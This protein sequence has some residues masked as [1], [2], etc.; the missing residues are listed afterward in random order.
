MTARIFQISFYAQRPL[1]K[2]SLIHR[3]LILCVPSSFRTIHHNSQK[4]SHTDSMKS[5][6][7][8]P[9]RDPNTLS[10]YNKWLTAHTTANL[11]IQFDQQR[12]SGN[13]VLT[14]KSLSDSATKDI[15][16]DTSHLDISDIRVND[17]SAEWELLPR[18]EPYGSALKISLDSGLPADQ[19]VEV[20]MQISTTKSCTALQWLTPAQTSNKKH[21]YMFSQCQAIHARSIFPCQDTP[22]V[23]STFDF[24]ITSPLPVIASGLASTSN[25]TSPSPSGKSD[26]YKFH[27]PLPIPSYLFAIASGDI[28][29]ASIGP[30]SVVATSPDQLSACV[31]ELSADTESFLQAAEKIVYP[32]AW[33]QYNVL[34]LPP[35]FPYGGME[36]PIFTFATPTIISHD[37]QNVDVIAHELAHSWSGNLVSNASWQH[38][39]LNEGWTTY[40]ERRILAAIHGNDAWRDFSAI[41]GWQA[42][43]ESVDQYG[44]THEFTKLIVNLRGQDPDD[45]FSSVPYEKGFNLLYHLEKLVTQPKFDSFIP[46]Y[47]TKWRGKSLDSYEFR[48]TLLDFFADDPTA[49]EQ[50]AAV[51]WHTW[52]YAPG[53]PP[54]PDFDTQLVRPAYDLA[55]KWET[56]TKNNNKPQE[57]PFTP[58]PSDI[59]HLIG[60]QL[61]VFLDRLLTLSSSSDHPASA[62][63]A[64]LTAQMGTLYA[65]STSANVEL[66]SRWCQLALRARDPSCL[67]LVQD[68]LATVGRMKFVRPLY[69]IP[70]FPSSSFFSFLFFSFP[71]PPSLFL[72]AYRILGFF[73]GFFF[74][75]FCI[76]SLHAE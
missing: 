12:L 59:A 21:P 2:W 62:L 43:T 15:L 18:M 45:A 38:F 6:T 70:F 19:T 73:W 71:T 54:K 20:L 53:L 52:F 57:E 8:D 66:S 41:I 55:E 36:N 49:S 69:V 17:K 23:K 37:R 32:Y 5:P 1:P 28:V 14:L 9:P 34:V 31:D 63:P 10:N 16:L 47:F 30:R 50:L 51:D 75:T 40:L 13:V 67:P 56:L 11:E 65:L 25:P 4:P 35:S 27:Q 64:P 74:W 68:L 58:H 39:W 61:V 33:Q 48:A 22:D 60:N 76:V 72:R 3:P 24:N 29:S 26:L 46:H 7:M 42:L 44:A